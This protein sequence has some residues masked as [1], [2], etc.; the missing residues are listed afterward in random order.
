LPSDQK[1]AFP[2]AVTLAGNPITSSSPTS[3]SAPSETATL[4]TFGADA[5][6]PP[7]VL[8]IRHWNRLLGGL[9][10]CTS[11]RLDWATLMRRTHATDVLECSQCHG[12]L[13][14]LAAITE[15]DVAREILTRLGLAI[16]EPRPARARDPTWEDAAQTELHEAE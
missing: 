10:L 1:A 9:L 12:R 5:D 16:T 6:L 13:R 3:A 8:P 14:V 2:P 7:N 4:V 11:P 15:P